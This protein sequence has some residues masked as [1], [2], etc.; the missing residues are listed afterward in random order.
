MKNSMFTLA[1]IIALGMSVAARTTFAADSDTKK[2]KPEAAAPRRPGGNPE[3]RLDRM[4]KDLNLTDDQKAKLKT[5]FEDETAKMKSLREDTSVSREDRR[6]KVQDIRKD[7]DAKVKAVLNADQ[8]AKW[9]KQR[10]E[11]GP[12]RRQGQNQENK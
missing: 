9:E 7:T 1:L 5:I 10:A 2:E 8:F 12:R 11:R 3:A 6:T 4:A